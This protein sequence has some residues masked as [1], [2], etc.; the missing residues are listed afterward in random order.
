MTKMHVRD[1]NDSDVPGAA[2]LLETLA[3][4]Y[5][6]HDCT[7][8]QASTFI[9]DNDAASLRRLLDAGFVFHVADIDGEVAGFVGVR[10]RRHL[11]HLFVAK[12]YHRRGIAG[13][14]WRHARDVALQGEG[15]ACFTVNSSLHAVQVYESFGFVRSGAEQCV[16]GLRFNPMTLSV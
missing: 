1:M 5:I 8:E 3:R 16:N 4:E 15:A 12:R 14:L 11:Y 9:R 13:A 2:R 7:P 6:V 10:E